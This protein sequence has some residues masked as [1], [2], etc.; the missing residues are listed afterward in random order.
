MRKRLLFAGVTLFF[1]VGA[2]TTS[3]PRLHYDPHVFTMA[4]PTPSFPIRTA[5]YP[6]CTATRQDRCRQVSA[7]TER[8]ARVERPRSYPRL[9]LDFQGLGGPFEPVIE[10]KPRRLRARPAPSRP[11]QPGEPIGL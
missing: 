6:P 11:V 8:L 9:S 4:D 10:E 3:R 7:R 2:A 5:A 1:A